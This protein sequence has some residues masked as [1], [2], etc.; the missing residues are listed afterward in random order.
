MLI[1]RIL[2]Q[3]GKAS[4][5]SRRVRRTAYSSIAEDWNTTSILNLKHQVQLF[6]VF[7]PS[8]E[9]TLILTALVYIDGFHVTSNDDVCF[10]FFYI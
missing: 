4:F 6:S 9:R 5:W 1:K 7:V 8:V 3:V 10:D 2:Q